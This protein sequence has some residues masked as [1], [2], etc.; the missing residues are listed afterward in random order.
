[1]GKHRREKSPVFRRRDKV[2]YAESDAGETAGDCAVDVAMGTNAGCL[3]NQGLR[4]AA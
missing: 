4:L 3:T 2:R 1:M